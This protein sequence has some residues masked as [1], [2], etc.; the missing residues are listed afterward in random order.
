MAKL[1]MDQVEQ[2][3]VQDSRRGRG[4]PPAAP[5]LAGKST[6]A[7]PRNTE[8][9][10]RPHYILIKSKIILDKQLRVICRRQELKMTAA[11]LDFPWP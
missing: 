7:R 4:A 9:E 6:R 10:R 1:M 8:Y 2:R 11:K 3:P 5:E